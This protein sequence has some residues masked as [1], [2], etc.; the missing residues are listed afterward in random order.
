[1]LNPFVNV[2]YTEDLAHAYRYTM[3]DVGIDFI[4]DVKKV[5]DILIAIYYDDASSFTIKDIEID[6]QGYID[7]IVCINEDPIFPLGNLDCNLIYHSFKEALCLGLYAN[8]EG[9]VR[10]YS[11][12]CTK[13]KNVE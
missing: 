2:E 4:G 11:Y 3:S 1:M 7:G 10:E 5:Y 12:M 13:Q 9:I 8:R 6:S